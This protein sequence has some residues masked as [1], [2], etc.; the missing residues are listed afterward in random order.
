MIIAYI[1]EH[2]LQTHPMIPLLQITDQANVHNAYSPDLD[3]W[4]EG[5]PDPWPTQIL[6]RIAAVAEHTYAP[7]LYQLGNIDFQVTR[8]LLGVSM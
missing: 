5:S 7:Q 6:S 8:G 3:L 4:L 2:P 1:G